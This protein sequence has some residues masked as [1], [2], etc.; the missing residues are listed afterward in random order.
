MKHHH[1]RF[2]IIIYGLLAAAMLFVGPNATAAF[3]AGARA[4]I[5]SDPDQFV[6]GGQAV[7]GS[8][9][10]LIQLAPSVDFGFG[11]NVKLTTL[12]LDLQFN[13]PSLPMVSPNV[14]IGAGPTLVMAKPDGGDSNTD[15]GLSLLAGLRIPM[16]A[17]SSCNIEARY[18]LENVPDLKILLGIMFGL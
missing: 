1:R 6:I 12:N 8:I 10:P 13:L 15:I 5:S 11:N 9:L 17:I 7:I 2:T 3:K 18:G 16:A 4:G 14:Y